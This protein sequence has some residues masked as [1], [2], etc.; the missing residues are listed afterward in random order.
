METAISASAGVH[1]PPK[2]NLARFGM[3]TFLASEAMLF[4][5]LISAYLILW[6]SRG[7]LFRP[8]WASAW[9]VTLTGMNTVILVGSSFTLLWGEKNVVKGLS[10]S[11]PLLIT[12]VMG[13]TFVGIQ[14][15]EWTNLK[16]HEN[17]WFNTAGTYSSTF[18]T[19]TGF[20]GLHVAIGVLLLFSSLVYSLRGRFTP[21]D[22]SFLECAS[23]YWHFVDIVW[24]FLFSILYV[25]PL[26][27]HH[28]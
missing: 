10:A 11:L 23:L 4:A 1:L 16:E 5:G 24:V 15:F 17:L 25:L 26:F 21:H 13:A 27:L 20:H 22:H 14:A 12:T 18:F 28:H 2:I 7:S 9:P 19:L 8:D 6:I 3:L